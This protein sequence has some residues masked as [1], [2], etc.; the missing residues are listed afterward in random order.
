VTA[1]GYVRSVGQ[2]RRAR[3]I[4]L[5][6]AV[7][8]GVVIVAGSLARLLLPGPETV[9]VALLAYETTLCAVAIAMTVGLLSASW[10]RAA[11]T[12]LVVELGG[13][14]SGTLR[15]ELARALGDPS[16]EVG[17]WRPEA[18]AFA[19]AQ[20]REVVLPPAGSDRAATTVEREHEPVAV[21]IHDSA[22][23]QDPGLMEA[24][25]SAA[26]LEAANARL[27]RSVHAR[28]VELEASRR[29]VLAAG[30]EER[31]RLER[32]LRD[33]AERRLGDLGDVLAGTRESSGNA[34]MQELIARAQEQLTEA[35]DD[36]DRL[37]LGLHPRSLS[38]SGLE[39][40]L[41]GVARTYPIPM[42]ITA[43]P[44]RLPS[45]V[46]LVAYFVCSEALSNAAKHA[47]ASSVVVSVTADDG[48][49]VIEVGDDGVGGADLARG[50]GLRNLADRVEAF[51]GTLAMESVPGRGTRLTAEVPLGGEAG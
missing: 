42:R 29:R 21:L 40:A 3:G 7:G 35:L 43:P 18:R 45:D 36:L 37:A 26:H 1:I 14:R 33:G 19:D 17:Y 15:E 38:E 6:I 41:A 23:L 51:G 31:R 25:T 4:A 44:E 11:V 28:V 24:L 30:D 10:E 16:L 32:G 27:Q 5:R 13:A 22:L 34:R 20:G 50:T 8:L 49:A 2:D 46:E 47:S 39:G 9:T 48:H 12:D